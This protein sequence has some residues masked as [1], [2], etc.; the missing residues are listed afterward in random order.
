MFEQLAKF[1]PAASDRFFQ[2][3][4]RAAGSR[5]FPEFGLSRRWR[6]A[7]RTADRDPLPAIQRAAG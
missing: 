2:Q 6:L 4:K 7:A 1:A 5:E 3:N